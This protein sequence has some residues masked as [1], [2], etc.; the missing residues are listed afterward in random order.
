MRVHLRFALL[1]TSFTIIALASNAPGANPNDFLDFS[2]P[3]VPGRLYV[4]PEAAMSSEPRPLILFLHGAGETGSNNSAQVNGNIDNL[5]DE[6]IERGAFLYAPQAITRNWSDITRTS[7]VMDKIDEAIGMYNIDPDRLY[8]TGLSMGGGGTWNMYNRHIDRFAASVPIA[9]ISPSGDFDAD[10]LVGK[11]SWAFHARNDGVVPTAATRG[12][13]STVLDA[14]S[15]AGL[16]YPGGR[17]NLD[18]FFYTN[19]A[20]GINFTE[21]LSG[22]HGIWGPVYDT[23]ELYEWMFSQ[24]LAVPNMVTPSDGAQLAFNNL[25]VRLPIGD[26][27]GTAIP[28]GT[29]FAA[30]GT[31]DLPDAQVAT[32]NAATLASLASSF[33]QFGSA[34]PIGVNGLEGLFSASVGAPLAA[35]DPLVGENI[36]LLLGDGED[37]ASSDSLFV[38]KSDEQF[39]ADSPSTLTTISLGDD[40]AFGEILLGSEGE[41]FGNRLGGLR[42][43]LVAAAVNVIP[44]PQSLLILL[45]GLTAFTTQRSRRE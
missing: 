15:A 40:L 26:S 10:R 17:G 14:A 44:E 31:L 1:A 45:L 3:S 25:N 32:T 24:E 37:I 29:G 28:A 2:D 41:V 8:I 23:P 18:T 43:G 6:A 5:F 33:T 42:P 12:V 38:F 39:T 20:V 22:G 35:D 34:L 4:P 16:T 36:Y 27:G 7:T 19:E 30:V 13:V 21:F 9:A 11:P